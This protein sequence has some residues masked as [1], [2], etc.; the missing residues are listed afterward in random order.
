MLLVL[1]AWWL[2][3]V[4]HFGVNAFLQLS[5]W[6][7]PGAGREATAPALLRWSWQ[8]TGHGAHRTGLL[9]VL[10]VVALVVDARRLTRSRSMAGPGPTS[11]PTDGSAW[12]TADL[13]PG[14][15]RRTNAPQASLPW[16]AGLVDGLRD[17]AVVVLGDLRF[18]LLAHVREPGRSR[19][20]AAREGLVGAM[21]LRRSRAEAF[22]DEARTTGRGVG[23]ARRRVRAV[24]LA[25]LLLVLVASVVVAPWLAERIGASLTRRV[26]TGCP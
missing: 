2:V 21:L 23:V 16:V 7:D 15:L 8:L 25:C 22:A 20:Q 17:V 9:V 5:A 26:D 3:V 24:A 10:L 11:A 1:A 14:W 18:V 13:V 19:T 4:D 6:T 12:F